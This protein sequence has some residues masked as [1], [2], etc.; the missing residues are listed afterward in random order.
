GG[1]EGGT[2]GGEAPDDGSQRHDRPSR[3][4]VPQI[5]EDRG[6]EE[7]N[8][9]EERPEEAEFRVRDL[10]VPADERSHRG[11][12]VAIDVVEEVEERQQRQ[13][14]AGGGM[15]RPTPRRAT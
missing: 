2:G 8:D 12:D 14:V 5:A 6:R 4:T 3:E 15:G 1:R 13:D 9:E 11:D 10:E 7:V